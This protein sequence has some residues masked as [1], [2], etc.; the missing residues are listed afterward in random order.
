MPTVADIRVGNRPLTFKPLSSF[1][2]YCEIFCQ[3]VIIN[4]VTLFLPSI[5]QYQFFLKLYCNA[6][7]ARLSTPKEATIIFGSM[8][9]AP[10]CNTIVDV[11]FCNATILRIANETTCCSVIKRKRLIASQADNYNACIFRNVF[12]D[13]REMSAPIKFLCAT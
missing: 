2:Q 3:R 12:M 5:D 8:Q 4:R 6:I 7:C 13:T 10:F 11:I 1:M 9:N